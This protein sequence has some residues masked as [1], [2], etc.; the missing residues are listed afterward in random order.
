MPQSADCILLDADTQIECCAYTS[1]PCMK[2][3]D[4]TSGLRLRVL[5][6]PRSRLWFQGVDGYGLGKVVLAE[7]RIASISRSAISV[8]VELT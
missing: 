6:S 4:F 8:I 3:E 7:R 1:F 2:L 5:L